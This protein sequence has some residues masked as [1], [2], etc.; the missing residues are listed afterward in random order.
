MSNLMSVFPISS[1]ESPSLPP[2]T[3]RNT[4]YGDERPFAQW[5]EESCRD[6][7]R[8][9][10]KE[11]AQSNANKQAKPS[12]DETVVLS[13]SPEQ[14]VSDVADLESAAPTETPPESPLLL[15]QGQPEAPATETPD[16]EMSEESLLETEE[17]VVRVLNP[18]LSSGTPSANS[19]VP[20]PIQKPVETA[21]STPAA[22][23]PAM[24][25]TSPASVPTPTPAP[26]QAQAGTEA[27]PP[28]S[29]DSAS[30]PSPAASTPSEAP[31]LPPQQD[32]D[33][34]TLSEPAKA[35]ESTPSPDWT[36]EVTDE[37]I[38]TPP[39][40]MADPVAIAT[41]PSAPAPATSPASETPATTQ[42]TPDT[43]VTQVPGADTSEGFS[44]EGF[45]RSFQSHEE[46]L[47]HA[48]LQP[49][50]PVGTSETL[51]SEAPAPVPLP[52]TMGGPLPSF[53]Q[54][55]LLAQQ[56]DRF[57]LHSVRSDSHSIRIE[58]EPV[59]LGRVTLQCRETSDGLS[60][61]IQVQNNQI[62]SLLSA[63]E[64]DLRNS[65]ESQ[66]MQMGKFSV[67]CRDGEGRSDSDRP[68]QHREPDSS[69]TE[70]RRVET[71][72]TSGT[73]G[74]ERGTRLGMRNRWVA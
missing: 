63:Q 64:Q 5:L 71:K 42:E 47:A 6:R 43:T 35:T 74:S 9:P 38:E 20:T 37:M 19:A 22:T 57:V 18:L 16:I 23:D 24:E 53:M 73:S 11:N 61:E 68:S 2:L 44:G 72:S 48:A 58:L 33:V 29:I 49:P 66:G 17:S 7:P 60:V 13:D 3:E 25:A 65:L 59:S 56:L 54:P 62:R 39:Q 30:L 4:L 10:P 40:E 50:P 34:A 36:A 32:V 31:A 52:S 15:A 46:S 69:D 26:A 27:Q 12:P 70:G 51:A 8:Q 28:E 41:A 14:M 67:T 21:T 1:G 55:A 45:S